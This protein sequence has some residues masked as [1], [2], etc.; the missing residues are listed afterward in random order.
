VRAVLALAFAWLTAVAS[1]DGFVHVRFPA[2]ESE[3]TLRPGRSEQPVLALVAPRGEDDERHVLA[4]DPPVLALAAGPLQPEASAPA[5]V[6]SGEHWG[7]IARAPRAY[8]P[9]GP[10][11]A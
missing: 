5:R 10:P 7:T 8:R 3:A 9:T 1:L 4:H 6:R 2:V 11:S